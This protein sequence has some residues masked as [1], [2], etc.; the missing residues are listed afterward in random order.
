M[1]IFKGDES[2][3]D[4]FNRSVLDDEDGNSHDD[5]NQH[6]LY[7]GLYGLFIFKATL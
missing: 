7:V 4:Y 2:W 1:G 5:A 6:L 3:E